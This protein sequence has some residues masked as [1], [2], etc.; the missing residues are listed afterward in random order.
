[1]TCRMFKSLPAYL[2]FFGVI[3]R[4]HGEERAERLE[5]LLSDPENSCIAVEI[6]TLLAPLYR[7]QGRLNESRAL[8]ESVIDDGVG[9]LVLGRPL[10]EV[11][12]SM[13]DFPA[14]WRA[15]ER[16][17]DY[18]FL[19]ADDKALVVLAAFAA[20]ERDEGLKCLGSLLRKRKGVAL[21]CQTALRLEHMHKQEE[22]AAMYEKVVTEVPDCIAANKGFL[23]ASLNARDCHRARSAASTLRRLPLDE[24]ARDLLAF[25]ER[26][27]QH[28]G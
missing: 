11:C 13:K 2:R 24:E 15:A 18:P 26:M 25:F 3:F 1:M 10:A 20:G 9:E 19:S 4:A 17:K 14:A 6:I 12:L 23:R 8:L 21:S 7:E 22:A 5:R 27:C 28:N 16:W